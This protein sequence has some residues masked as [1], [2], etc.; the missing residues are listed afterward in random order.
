MQDAGFNEPASELLQANTLKLRICKDRFGRRL[1]AKASMH[2][3]IRIKDIDLH[4]SGGGDQV[5]AV[6]A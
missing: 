1:G 2:K 5:V 6:A 4:E 3:T